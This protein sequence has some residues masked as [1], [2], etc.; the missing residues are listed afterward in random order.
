MA[1]RDVRPD[2]RCWPGLQIVVDECSLD[3]RSVEGDDLVA[4]VG[5]TGGDGR[6]DVAAADDACMDG[7]NA[8]G[9]L[10]IGFRVSSMESDGPPLETETFLTRL[11]RLTDTIRFQ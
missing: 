9:D 7:G 6:A 4:E 8:A 10:R 2:G 11:G 3:A 5:E 1:T